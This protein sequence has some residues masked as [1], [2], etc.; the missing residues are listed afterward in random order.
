MSALTPRPG[1]MDILPYKGGE[2]KIEGVSRIIK[3]ASNEGPFGPA[4][5]AIVAINNASSL[6]HRYPD[7]SASAL[8]AKLA[9]KHNIDANRIVC[10]AGSDELLGILCRAYAGPGDE[11]L[12]CEH[13]FLMYPIAAKTA[14]ATPVKAKECNL[15]TD[16][17]ALLAAVTDKTKV[18][19]FAN[20]NNPTGTYISKSEV[21]R[22]HAGLRD[23]ILLVIDAAYAEFMT[24]EDYDAGIELVEESQ[25]VVMTRTFSKMYGLG[26]I[27]LGWSYA[28]DE[29]TDVINRA[30][31]PFNV[32]ALALAAGEAALDDDD[33]VEKTRTHNTK[34]LRWLESE[35]KSIGLETTVSHANFALVKFPLTQGKTSSD[36][37]AYLRSKGIIV[38]AMGSYGLGE[39]LR[40][41]IGTEEENQLCMAALREFMSK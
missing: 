41:T 4:P 29:V 38:R 24:Q 31:N 11:V 18:V 17:D 9:Q 22:L 3:L 15:T 13:G 40:I 33:F 21:K 37:D 6:Q 36:A 27:R 26:G 7:G 34:W 1:L 30:R 32:T 20:P 10:G 2:S 23:D 16:V 5:S 12:Y 28:S 8:R 35:C 39:Y 14:G 25:N 19:F